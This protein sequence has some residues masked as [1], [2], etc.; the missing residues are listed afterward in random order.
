MFWMGNFLSI[1][2]MVCDFNI[3]SYFKKIG[4]VAL[5]NNSFITQIR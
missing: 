2:A 4:K 5:Y 3:I 1:H